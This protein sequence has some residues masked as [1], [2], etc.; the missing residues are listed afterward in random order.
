MI[1]KMI[2]PK[3]K[4]SNKRF[5]TVTFETRKGPSTPYLGL[6]QFMPQ[7]G[8]IERRR[9]KKKP[10]GIRGLLCPVNQDF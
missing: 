5:R 9:I 3:S 4:T 6:F 7:L 10:A 2:T 1:K 8:H